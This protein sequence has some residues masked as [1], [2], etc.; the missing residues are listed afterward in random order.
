YWNLAEH[1]LAKASFRS[2][3]EAGDAFAALLDD[4]VRLRLISDVPLGA[5]LSGGIDSSTIVAAMNHAR[6]ADANR[7]F[8]LGFGDRGYDELARRHVTVCLSGDGG[9]E[10]FAGYDTYTADKLRRLTAWVPRPL[11]KAA[12]AAADTLMPVSLD[13]LGADEKIR[14]FLAGHS[15]DSRHAHY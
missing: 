14:R 5:F 8:S 7:T 2:E 15:F 3:D 13:K 9:D 6:P 12:A 10:N 4:A 1:F 11:L